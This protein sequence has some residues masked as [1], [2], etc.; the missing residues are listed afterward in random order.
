MKFFKKPKKTKEQILA[1]KKLMWVHEHTKFMLYVDE[2]DL[3][4][5]HKLL[6]EGALSSGMIR[7]EDV[8]KAVNFDGD[9]IGK[10]KILSSHMSKQGV[11][12]GSVYTG[13]Y[14][15]IEAEIVEGEGEAFRRTS[16]LVDADM[17]EFK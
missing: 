10:L 12:Q 15:K 13:D 11:F 6:L 3:M 8:Y 5:D 7:P 9:T 14:E 17:E 2:V 1:Q 16:M 4:D